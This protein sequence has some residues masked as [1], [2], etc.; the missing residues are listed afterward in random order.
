MGKEC[1]M[2][3]D[4]PSNLWDWGINSN[5]KI[6]FITWEIKTIIEQIWL[7]DNKRWV[8]HEWPHSDILRKTQVALESLKKEIEL[9]EMWLIIKITEWSNFDNCCG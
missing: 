7:L 8:L 4:G 2:W 3:I 6:D 9:L 5:Q 1:T